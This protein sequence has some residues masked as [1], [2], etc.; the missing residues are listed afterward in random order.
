M[1]ARQKITKGRVATAPAAAAKEEK[2]EAPVI[3]PATDEEVAAALEAIKK[4]SNQCPNP[5]MDTEYLDPEKVIFTAS[6]KNKDKKSAD[7]FTI[8]I[9]YPF[10]PR[11]YVGTEH[12][13]TMRQFGHARNV[14]LFHQPPSTRRTKL[15]TGHEKFGSKLSVVQN[16]YPDRQ[17]KTHHFYQ[18]VQ[19]RLIDFTFAHH[20][21]WPEVCGQV[22]ET[23]QDFIKF[24]WCHKKV[25]MMF[26]KGPGDPQYTAWSIICKMYEDVEIYL[27]G[28]KVTHGPA[29]LEKLSE[30]ASAYDLALMFNP[31]C[32]AQERFCASV[33]ARQVSIIPRD[34]TVQP[35]G[36]FLKRNRDEL[37]NSEPDREHDNEAPM[38]TGNSA[39]G[40]DSEPQ[41][42]IPKVE[43][44]EGTEQAV[45]SQ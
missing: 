20:A 45:E 21:E 11:D 29:A 40:D 2:P 10:D 33:V 5:V 17:P 9:T 22:Y 43:A 34:R 26:Y 16:V 36:V 35:K 31:V 44:G 30:E 6:F 13:V 12:E 41:A 23:R 32:W 18:R 19:E 38:D 25:P 37:N 27:D 1:S 8:R 42:K 15:M 3:E 14:P 7:E 28:Q 4:R 39:N 24:C